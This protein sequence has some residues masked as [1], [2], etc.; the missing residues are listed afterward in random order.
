VAALTSLLNLFFKDHQPES[1]TG[2][3]FPAEAGITSKTFDRE[4]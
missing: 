2:E 4:P 3:N 1:L